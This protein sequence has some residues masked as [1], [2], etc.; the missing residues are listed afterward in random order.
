MLFNS[1][2]FI[3]FFLCFFVVWWWAKRQDQ[4]RW[5]TLV[6]FS[7]IFYGWWDW[8]FLFLL[9][10]SG[11]IDYW[12]GLGMERQPIRRKLYLYLSL[13]GN[14]GSLAIF[15]YSQLFARILDDVGALVGL[16]WD[17]YAQLP[18]FS[19]IL[20]VGI[21]FYTFQSMS[22]TLDIYYKKLKPTH[23]I[24][25][26]FAYLSLFP[27]LVAGPILRAKDLLY[28][29]QQDRPISYRSV[30]FG[31]RLMVYGFFQKMV[32]ADNIAPFVNQAFA[33][34]HQPTVYWYW[35]LVLI[36]FAFQIYFDFAGYSAI[37]RGL[38]RLMGYRFRLNFD[39]PYHARSLQEFWR[40]WHVS[41]STW[42]RDYVYRPLGGNRVSAWKIYRNL[43]ITFLLSALWHGA[44]YHYI[45]WGVVHALGLSLERWT[46]WP[47]RLAAYPWLA[48]LAWPIVWGQVL[49]AWLFFRVEHWAD[50]GVVGQQLFAF[51][52]SLE[53]PQ[54]LYYFDGLIMVIVAI[55]VEIWYYI[56]R[57]VPTIRA[58]T[59]HPVYDS[60]T[61]SILITACIYLRGPASDFVYFQF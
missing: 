3:V 37:A 38:A 16:D 2:P 30:W 54:L 32:L 26:F 7:A 58:W 39:H 24:W 29:L 34:V 13:L 12:A 17:C 9:L 42:F 18:T 41:L 31:L 15:K 53:A 10:F 23:N 35:W 27:Q 44:Y 45:L 52:A 36:G 25:H 11:S 5:I 56:K 6:V 20:P 50:V 47:K 61:M 46:A 40:R 22:Y 57:Q 4:S 33:N 14:I 8:R 51:N 60:I 48:W 1:L 43:W 59:H 55:S 21:S 49:L 19:L 28:Q